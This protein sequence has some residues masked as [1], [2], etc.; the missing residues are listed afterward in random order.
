MLGKISCQ[1]WISGN[2]GT[3]WSYRSYPYF[4]RD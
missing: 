1:Y 3:V 4:W 2:P